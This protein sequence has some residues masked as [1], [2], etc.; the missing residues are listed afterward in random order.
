[1]ILARLELGCW[2]VTPDDDWPVAVFNA[3]NTIQTNN[4][5]FMLKKIQLVKWKFKLRFNLLNSSSINDFN[6]N[7]I[8]QNPNHA[9]KAKT[10]P[11]Q[12]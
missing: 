11:K 1:M 4:A 10:D 6:Q 12:G 5:Y 9:K 7:I 2:A 3:N 8:F